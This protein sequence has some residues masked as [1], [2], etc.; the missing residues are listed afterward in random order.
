MVAP[1]DGDIPGWSVQTERRGSRLKPYVDDIPPGSTD[2][3]IG[4]GVAN[5]EGGVRGRDARARSTTKR[6]APDAKL[7][8]RL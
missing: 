5:T 8:K 6:C 1:M 4:G 7:A 3:A 2:E